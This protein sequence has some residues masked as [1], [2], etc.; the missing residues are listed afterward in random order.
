MNKIDTMTGIIKREKRVG[1]MTHLVV[2]YPSLSKTLSLAVAMESA[3]ADFIE[4]QIP[5]SDPLADGP[6]IMNACST[7]LKNGTMVADAMRVAKD[8]SERASVPIL[9]M[10]YY[11]N[12]FKYGVERFCADSANAGVS[13]LILPD[14]PIDEEPAEHFIRSAED[15]GLYAIRVMS[16]VST[17]DRLAKNARVANGF[18]YCT[19]RQ[20]I[21]GTR[22]RIERGAAS[23]IDNVRRELRVPV[24]IGFG[25]SRREHVRAVA[26]HAD[27]VVIGSAVIN[28]IDRDRRAAEKNVCIF[29]RGLMGN[30]RL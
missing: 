29:I 23:Y 21:T 20:G 9:F 14:M 25:I 11:N 30:D 4:L 8:I 26:A 7:S 18:V 24:A 16:P 1:L 27:I 17:P 6:T 19:A 10:A 5:F 13:G 15:N 28:V 22:G 3:G 2:G 12:V